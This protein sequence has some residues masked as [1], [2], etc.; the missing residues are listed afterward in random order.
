MEAL[1]SVE[2]TTLTKNLTNTS[3]KTVTE[4]SIYVLEI[5]ATVLAGLNSAPRVESA[6]KVTSQRCGTNLSALE[7]LV[8]KWLGNDHTVQCGTQAYNML[9]IAQT[10]APGHRYT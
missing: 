2:R 3:T 5:S 6:I 4:P 10:E 9:P 7:K 1:P 8:N